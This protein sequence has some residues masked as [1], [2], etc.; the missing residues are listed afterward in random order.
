MFTLFKC[1]YIKVKGWSSN[2]TIIIQRMRCIKDKGWI[3][4]MSFE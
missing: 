3:A 4:S 2:K 1:C